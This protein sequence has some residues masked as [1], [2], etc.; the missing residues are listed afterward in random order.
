MGTSNPWF[1]TSPRSHISA[2]PDLGIESDQG[3]FSS[4]ETNANTLP[5]HGKALTI[6][7]R[8]YSNI[9]LTRKIVESGKFRKYYKDRINLVF[10]K[11][12]INNSFSKI[13]AP[14]LLL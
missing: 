14:F 6:S 5:A 13:E 10:S 4:L 11:L 9:I 1:P 8:K 7:I 2:S 12:N 3:R